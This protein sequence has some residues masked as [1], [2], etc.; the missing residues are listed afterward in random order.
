[1]HR[2][3]KKIKEMHPKIYKK[4]GRIYLYGF[5]S[6]II[7]MVSYF[8]LVY[9]VY[10]D[11][12]GFIGILIPLIPGLVVL[13]CAIGEFSMD[14]LILYS[15]GIQP[16]APKFN[17]PFIKKHGFIH[18]NQLRRI[19]YREEYRTGFRSKLNSVDLFLKDLKNDGP[20]KQYVDTVEDCMLIINTFERYNN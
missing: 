14:S 4:F 3:G 6:L 12:I 15:N 8:C 1:M 16:Y 18:F 5:I 17:L 19:R 10:S 9:F 7:I 11:F 13:I 20:L 2:P